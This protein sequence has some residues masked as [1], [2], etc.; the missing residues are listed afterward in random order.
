M[1]VC[2]T[3]TYEQHPSSTQRLDTGAHTIGVPEGR[4]SGTAWAGGVN[5]KV[6]PST[7]NVCSRGSTTLVLGAVELDASEAVDVVSLGTTAS[8]IASGGAPASPRAHMAKAPI[9]T[10]ITA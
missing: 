6:T 4:G 9:A 5:E 1:N 2:T 8:D 10:P 7:S 3:N